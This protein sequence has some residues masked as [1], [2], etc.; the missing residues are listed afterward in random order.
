MAARRLDP[1]KLDVAALVAD[2]GRIEGEIDG[3]TLERWREMQSPPADVP[4]PTVRWA[5]RGEQRQ[6]SGG[7]PQTWLH[8][9][10]A[11]LAWP[12]CQRCL[13]PFRTPID[14]E[15]A[16]R[17]VATEREAEALD[18]ESEDDVLALSPSFDL[19][20]LVE[21]ELVLAWPLVPRHV[22]CS[23]PQHDAGAEPPA[24]S[25]PFAALAAWKSHRP[26]A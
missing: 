8:L 21:D 25:G 16:F 26:K 24:E 20:G 15:R 2:A 1:H 9:Q 19:I 3:Q 12:T 7:A 10:V 13:Q 23:Q 5:A 22:Q 18:A 11:A 17:F 6:R 14:L 4:L